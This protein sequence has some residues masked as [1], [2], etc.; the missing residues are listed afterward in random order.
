[1]LKE[2]IGE[3][4]ANKDKIAG[5]LRFASTQ[6]D[7]SDETVSLKDY[8]GRMKPEQ[9]KIYYVTAESFNAAR[10]SPH[11]AR[12]ARGAGASAGGDDTAP[13]GASSR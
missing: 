13:G 8:I 9:E 1:M 2:G 10:S 6:G 3:D 4:F 11:R 12:A 5:L 7:T